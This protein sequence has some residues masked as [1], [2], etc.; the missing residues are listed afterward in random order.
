MKRI[1]A[2]AA[3]TATLGAMPALAGGPVA[4]VEALVDVVNAK[5][6]GAK[7]ITTEEVKAAVEAKLA[8]VASAVE[9]KKEGER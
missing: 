5:A 3:A 7:K 8:T 9:P 2:L 1:M 4:V 6:D